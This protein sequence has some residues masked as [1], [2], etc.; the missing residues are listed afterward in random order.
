MKI[1]LFASALAL[2]TAAIAQDATAPATPPADATAP[3]AAPD[4]S[5]P[6]AA[7]A[8][9]DATAPAA[10]PDASA[11]PMAGDSSGNMAGA[12]Q[13]ASS[14]DDSSLPKCSK[15]VTDKCVQGGKSTGHKAMHHKKK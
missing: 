14:V 6:P 2:S 10:A 4:A 12:Q 11:A 5:M 3:A 9:P 13:A 7:P 1:I 15:T 8:T